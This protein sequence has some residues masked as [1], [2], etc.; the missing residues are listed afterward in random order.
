MIVCPRCRRF[1]HAG[2]ACPFCGQALLDLGTAEPD[3]TSA[4]A[5]LA[6]GPPPVPR[7]TE[8]VLPPEM[9]IHCE[10]IGP[11]SP[12]WQQCPHR[13]MLRDPK[14]IAAAVSAVVVAIGVGVW[15][16]TRKE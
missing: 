16:S 12:Y 2:S 10:R 5:I 1:V 13:S 14:F 8:Q 4:N 3:L 9:S 11:D 6:Y 7:P 15:V